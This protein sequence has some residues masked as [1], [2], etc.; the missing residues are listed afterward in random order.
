MEQNTSMEPSGLT[1]QDIE[2]FAQFAQ[3][4]ILCR[5]E[6]QFAHLVR[7]SVRALL[8]HGSLI[9]VIGQID[10]EHVEICRVA[11]ID[12]PPAHLAQIPL[13]L[14]LRER[15]VVGRWLKDREPVVVQLPRDEAFLSE[16]ER[17][18]IE[19]YGLG[20][21]AIHGLLD[22]HARTGS[23]FS[24]AQ[25]DEAPADAW[26]LD[27]LRLVVPLLHA[28][29]LRL[30]DL[31]DPSVTQPATPLSDKE[32]QLL[33]WLAAG[34]SNIEI[35]TLCSRSQGNCMSEPRLVIK[36]RAQSDKRAATWLYNK[37]RTQ[38]RL[39]S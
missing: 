5:T 26:V 35:A 16:R 19:T 7:T 10:L 24:F 23:Y 14:N 27:R 1:A 22:L 38:G 25:V 30:D 6:A 39:R 33:Q 3:R 9:A 31:P 29:L 34:R 12:T 11:S 20:R 4:C 32:V 2:T 28:A 15:P 17:F 18:E 21:L 13:K 37:R 36:A 8:P